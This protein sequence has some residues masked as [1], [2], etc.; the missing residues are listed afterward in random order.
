MKFIENFCKAFN[1][2]GNIYGENAQDLYKKVSLY[3][4]PMINPDGID[5]VNN[6]VDENSNIYR[7]YLSIANNFPSI[8]FPNGWKANFNGVDL[9]NYQPCCKVL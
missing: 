4:V 2:N 6:V 7:N 5:L 3:I 1:V 9:K 8:T